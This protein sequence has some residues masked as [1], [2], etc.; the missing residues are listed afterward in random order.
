MAAREASPIIQRDEN[1]ADPNETEVAVVKSQKG[2]GEPTPTTRWPT[3]IEPLS[4]RRSTGSNSAALIAVKEELQASPQEAEGAWQWGDEEDAWQ[5]DWMSDD[6]AWQEWWGDEEGAWQEDS[7]DEEGDW[8]ETWDD[9]E[10]QSLLSKSLVDEATST[11]ATAATSSSDGAAA[12]TAATAAASSSDGAAASTATTAAASSS[13]GAASTAPT[14]AASSSDGAASTAPTAATSSSD[15]A[16]SMATTAALSDGV[17]TTAATAAV[18]SSKGAASVAAT[19]ATTAK[20]EFSSS[21]GATTPPLAQCCSPCSPRSPQTEDGECEPSP[22]KKPRNQEQEAMLW[23][24]QQEQDKSEDEGIRPLKMSSEVKKEEEDTDQDE[25]MDPLKMKLEMKEEAVVLA[26]EAKRMQSTEE[27]GLQAVKEEEARPQAVTEKEARLQ[28]VREEE[29]QEEKTTFAPL[30]AV[31]ERRSNEPP[32]DCIYLRKK[33][34]PGG[35]PRW[36]QLGWHNPWQKLS[37]SVRRQY[38]PNQKPWRGG[39][40]TNIVINLEGAS[41]SFGFHVK[42]AGKS[43]GKSKGKG[44]AKAPPRYMSI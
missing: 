17:T 43:K 24:A 31:E 44:E 16:A 33:D 21:E 26:K 27:A 3:A 20:N 18:S 28:A 29:E 19:A 30:Q 41:G 23:W 11:T 8:Q 1:V 9:E 32:A 36:R 15:C 7:G 4:K 14:A 38:G 10:L 40:N 5:E 12:S 22:R 6:G 2:F 39:G 35:H 42:G 25:G 34:W 13:D 37:P